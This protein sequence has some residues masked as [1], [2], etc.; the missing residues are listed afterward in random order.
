MRAVVRTIY[1]VAVQVALNLGMKYEIL[2]FSTINEIMTDPAV[3]PF[4]PSPGTLGAEITAPY[5]MEVDSANIREQYVIIGNGGHRSAPGGTNGIDTMDV[6]PHAATDSGLFRMIPFVIRPYADDLPTSIAK[7]YR[8]RKIMVINGSPFIAYYARKLNVESVTPEMAI[9]TVSNGQ[10]TTTPFRPSINDL[11]PLP[12]AIDG[13]GDG[14]F[15]DVLAMM[16]VDF[17][18]TEVKYLQEVGQILYGKPNL[19]IVSEIA[20]CSGVDK[21]VTARYPISGNQNPIPV[22]PGE[23]YEAVAV[24][25]N[26]HISTYLTPD[27]DGGF[28]GEYNLGGY[29]PLYPPKT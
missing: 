24:Q 22:A 10:S 1:G 8:L 11:K 5:D 6:L 4:Q 12:K 25:V 13:E 29:D 17:G 2:R 20:F 27:Y 15:V 28:G 21:P 18:P 3:V 14:A 7:N 16:N 19:A 9:T 23:K 26:T